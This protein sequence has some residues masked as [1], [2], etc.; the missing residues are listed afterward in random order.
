MVH[1]FISWSN[2]TLEKTNV[3]NMAGKSTHNTQKRTSEKVF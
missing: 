2:A 1:A 3:Q